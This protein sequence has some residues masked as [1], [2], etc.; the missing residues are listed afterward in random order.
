MQGFCEA[1]QRLRKMGY[2]LDLVVSGR[3]RDWFEQYAQTYKWAACDGRNGE[4]AGSAFALPALFG[5]R[6]YF[7]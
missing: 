4:C 2:T 1:L 5:S 7:E 6:E 3:Q